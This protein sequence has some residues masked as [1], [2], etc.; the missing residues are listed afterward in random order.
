[1]RGFRHVENRVSYLLRQVSC[2]HEPA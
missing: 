2:M 1:L